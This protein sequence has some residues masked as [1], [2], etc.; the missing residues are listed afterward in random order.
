MLARHD[1]GKRHLGKA[2]KLIFP[3]LSTGWQNVAS[4]KDCGGNAEEPPEGTGN[5]V[6]SG[7]RLMQAK[8]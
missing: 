7:P 1:L 2:G 3:L 6:N 5:G 8:G 4:R